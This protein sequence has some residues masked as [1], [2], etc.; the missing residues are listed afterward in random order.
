MGRGRFPV[1][2][3]HLGRL[4]RSV[5]LQPPK[6]NEFFSTTRGRVASPAGGTCASDPGRVGLDGS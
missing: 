1:P 3:L 4:S 6:P 2:N 5:A